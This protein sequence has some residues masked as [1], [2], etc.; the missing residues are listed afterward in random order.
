MNPTAIS[1]LCDGASPVLYRTEKEEK[2]PRA[3]R[4]ERGL[5]GLQSA[6]GAS[7]GGGSLPDSPRADRDF[8][9]Q[10]QEFNVHLNSPVST[11]TVRHHNQ[12]LCSKTRC[13]SFILQHLCV[14]TGMVQKLNLE[15]QDDSMDFISSVAKTL[16]SDG[17]TNWGRIVCLVALGAVVCDQLKKKS[18]DHCITCITLHHLYHLYLCVCVCNVCVFVL[19]EGFV[20]FSEVKGQNLLVKSLKAVSRVAGLGF[21][22]FLLHW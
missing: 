12:L 8:M 2:L 9:R 22:M 18:R 1:L 13:F 6:K 21:S 15:E 19:Q 5:E 10:V 16:F 3:E 14:S 20:E 7:M 4:P 17:T 11:R